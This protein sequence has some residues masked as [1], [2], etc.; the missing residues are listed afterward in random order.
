MKE[1]S[2][3]LSSIL[4]TLSPSTSGLLGLVY[5]PKNSFGLH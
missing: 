5:K 4:A 1:V 3:E 2:I